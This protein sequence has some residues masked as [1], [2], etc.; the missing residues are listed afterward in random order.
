MQTYRQQ[1]TCEFSWCQRWR[2]EQVQ[3]RIHS[4]EALIDRLT[5]IVSNEALRIYIDS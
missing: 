2:G 1:V 4:N 3:H 5:E